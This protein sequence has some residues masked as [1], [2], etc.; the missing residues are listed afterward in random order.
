M[1]TA[2]YPIIGFQPNETIT[3]CECASGIPPYVSDCD[4]STEMVAICGLVN[5][6]IDHIYTKLE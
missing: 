5:S 3:V 1:C 4:Q 2:Y 6:Y